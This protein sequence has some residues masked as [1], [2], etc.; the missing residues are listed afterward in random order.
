MTDIVERL[1]AAYQPE[2]D[3]LIEAADKIEQLR[4]ELADVRADAANLRI[5]IANLLGVR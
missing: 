2:L 3:V 4:E 5:E 1:R